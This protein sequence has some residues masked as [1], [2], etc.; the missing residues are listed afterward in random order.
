MSVSGPLYAGNRVI[1][2]CKTRV[3]ASVMGEVRV[4]AVWKMGSVRITNSSRM[5]ISAAVL[6]EGT[7]S[8][9]SNVTINPVEVADSGVYTCE[10]ALIS[11]AAGNISTRS[12]MNTVAIQGEKLR[13]PY[14]VQLLHN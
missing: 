7:T 14:I 8:F 5:N 4:V 13:E 11:D 1:I 2:T 9:V 10:S 3:D 12:T 6:A